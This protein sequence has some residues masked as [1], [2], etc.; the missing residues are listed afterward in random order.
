MA[1]NTQTWTAVGA[2]PRLHPNNLTTLQRLNIF[3]NELPLCQSGNF[4]FYVGIYTGLDQETWW[5][6]WAPVGRAENLG[7]TASLPGPYI[8][9]PLCPFVPEATLPHCEGPPTRGARAR[10]QLNYQQCL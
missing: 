8:H 10:S 5:Q 2:F 9:L 1:K 6:V 7:L 3:L 4:A